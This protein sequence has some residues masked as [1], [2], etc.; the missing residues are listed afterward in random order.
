MVAIPFVSR[1]ASSSLPLVFVLLGGGCLST[2][3][4][5]TSGQGTSGRG[6]GGQA[7]TGG[8]ETAGL[9]TNTLGL[10]ISPNTIDFGST[11]IGTTASRSLTLSNCSAT[12]ATGLTAIVDGPD[13]AFFAVEN[14]P[15]TLEAGT[16][17]TVTVS[18]SPLAVEPRSLGAVI[19]RASD[20]ENATLDL[21]GE[22]IEATPEISCIPSSIGFGQ[23]LTNDAG[24]VALLCINTGLSAPNPTKLVIDPTASPPVFFAQ[25]DQKTN[26]YP[27]DGL[28]PGQVAQIDVTYSPVSERYDIGT[29]LIKSNAT[30]SPALQIPLEG[31]GLFPP[32][33]QFEIDPSQLN[34]GDQPI[35]ASMSLSFDV[36]SQGGICLVE[37]PK[38]IDDPAGVFHVTSTSLAPDPVT[39]KITIPAS[40]NLSVM[41]AFSPT[42]TGIF[43]AELQFLISDPADPDQILPLYGTSP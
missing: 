17:T 13:Q 1:P 3:S 22:P 36:T 8:A 25:F 34:F 43:S 28:A 33:C 41:V 24:V 4:D 10:Y 18:Y 16:S 21:F 6:S 40:A 42:S 37:S 32:P 20:Q 9:C 23:V 2:G 31:Q 35:G 30:K 19:F 12:P 39:G 11:L 27:P 5:R 14:A 7:S 29:L 38:I 15:T 26:A